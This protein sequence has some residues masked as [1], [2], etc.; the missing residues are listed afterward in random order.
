MKNVFLE[1]TMSLDGFVA[2][3]DISTKYPMGVNGLRLHNWYFGAK[4]AEDEKVLA[5]TM[6]KAGAVIVG[7][8]TYDVAIDEAWEGATPFH[9]PAF[10][11]SHSIPQDLKE[12]FTVVT[13]GIESA[14]S[15]AQ[16]AAG[17]KDVW[18]MGGANIIQQ[19]IKAG[20][21]DEFHLH[22]APVLLGT[23]LRLFDH[24]GNEHIELIKN[25]IV[26]TPGALHINFSR[27]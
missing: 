27:P 15:K 20:L 5:E 26:D 21:Y 4:T 25:R 19:F 22:I 14:L 6:S 11:V 24:I 23:G 9:V 1:I 2:G 8:H 12:G 16:A 10:I 13:D 7:R 17:D 3:P 18:V